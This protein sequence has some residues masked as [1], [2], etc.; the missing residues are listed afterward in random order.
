MESVSQF[1]I[2]VSGPDEGTLYIEVFREGERSAAELIWR[3]DDEHGQHLV[4]II[5]PDDIALIV[6]EFSGA[7]S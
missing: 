7:S 6:Q 4:G 2:P 5:G 3:P 1:S